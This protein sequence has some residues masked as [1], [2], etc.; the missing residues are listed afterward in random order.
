MKSTKDMTKV[1]DEVRFSGD[2]LLM[3]FG[4]VVKKNKVTAEVKTEFGT[5]KVR[6]EKLNW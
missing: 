3:D 4:T 6:Y 2:G 5:V 1:G